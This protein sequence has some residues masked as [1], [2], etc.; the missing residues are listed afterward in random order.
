[1]GE[2]Q[3]VAPF[4]VLHSSSY[5]LPDWIRNVTFDTFLLYPCPMSVWHRDSTFQNKLTLTSLPPGGGFNWNWTDVPCYSR[6]DHLRYCSKQKK[7]KKHFPPYIAIRHIAA[8]LLLIAWC[9]L[10]YHGMVLH[11]TCFMTPS[12]VEV[13]FFFVIGWGERQHSM[14]QCGGP[15]WNLVVFLFQIWTMTSTQKLERERRVDS[16]HQLSITPL[17]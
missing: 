3:Q 14:S 13:T 11:A 8:S 7:K 6:S 2:W 9:N 5:I 17:H 1:M 4:P 15:G 10:I 12:S 16:A